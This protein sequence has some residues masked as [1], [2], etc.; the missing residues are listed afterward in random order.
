MERKIGGHKIVD[1]QNVGSHRMTTDSACVYF[2]QKDWFQT[3]CLEGR[4]IDDGGGHNI[5]VAEIGGVAVL[6]TPT[7][8]KFGNPFRRKCQS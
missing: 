5:F 2:V 7:F 1:D 4:C 3:A 6:S 8:C